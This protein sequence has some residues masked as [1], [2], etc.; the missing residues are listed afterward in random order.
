[1]FA[2]IHMPTKNPSSASFLSKQAHTH[3]RHITCVHNCNHTHLRVHTRSGWAYC[4]AKLVSTGQICPRSG[5]VRRQRSP[6]RR[7]R[8]T[9]LCAA[10]STC[11]A[12]A[13]TSIACGLASTTSLR[14]HDRNTVQT[15]CISM[16]EVRAECC[17]GVGWWRPREGWI[18]ITQNGKC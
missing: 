9:G 12:M 6:R 13:E 2:N 14:K 4:L 15:D 17:N 10:R 8:R 18:Y 16:V 3:T 1:M 5:C 7:C 11:G